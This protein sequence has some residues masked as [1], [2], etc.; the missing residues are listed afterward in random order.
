M[1]HTELSVSTGARKLLFQMLQY[2]KITSLHLLPKKWQLNL[3]HTEATLQSH[4]AWQLSTLHAHIVPLCKCTEEKY[5]VPI[6]RTIGHRVWQVSGTKHRWN[7][8]SNKI[9][10]PYLICKT[11]FCSV[12][13]NPQERLLQHC[14]AWYR[15]GEKGSWHPWGFIQRGG[16]TASQ[17]TLEIMSVS[18]MQTFRTWLCLSFLK[19]K[20]WQYFTVAKNPCFLSR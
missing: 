5:T 6:I 8:I 17:V 9:H 1:Y 19:W 20:S 14:Y 4:S 11:H 16:A 18:L 12:L 10:R 15:L 3:C 7:S 2:R 13:S